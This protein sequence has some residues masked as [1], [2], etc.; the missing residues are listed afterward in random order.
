MIEANWREKNE[1]WRK[2]SEELFQG[3]L[4]ATDQRS[5]D[6]AWYA[7]CL[8]EEKR[9]QYAHSQ[10]YWEEQ[11]QKIAQLATTDRTNLIR[12]IPTTPTQPIAQS[13]PTNAELDWRHTAIDLG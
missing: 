4:N 10:L 8:S 7:A 13:I 6:I 5:M 11:K 2:Q 1:Q 3:V 12:R 9:C